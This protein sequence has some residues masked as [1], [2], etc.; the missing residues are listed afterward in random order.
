MTTSWFLKRLFPKKFHDKEFRTA[1]V[2]ANIA[3]TISAQ[4]Y[5]LRRKRGWS[6]SALA[7]EA[8]MAQARI[9]VLEDP[10]YQGIAI[11]T[12]RRLAA[13]FDVALVVK[14]VS[15]GELIRS[16]DEFSEKTISVPSFD[17]ESVGV[18]LPAMQLKW[19]E[20]PAGRVTSGVALKD[21]QNAYKIQVA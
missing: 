13:A 19:N 9:S 14:F 15:F 8:G 20:P 16:A 6:Q 4:I 5:S 10:A 17:E 12:L 18:E 2:E 11:A 21:Y 7:R 3:N 1:Y